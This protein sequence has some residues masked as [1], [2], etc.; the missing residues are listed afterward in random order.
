MTD[1]IDIDIE[2][3]N[4]VVASMALHSVAAISKGQELVRASAQRVV[5]TSQQLV[6]VD[7]AA[8]R[9]SIHA[10]PTDGGLGAEI[11][12]TTSY[13]PYLE[14]GTVKMAPRAFMGPALDRETPGFIE[15]AA[16]IPDLLG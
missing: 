9:N 12:P 1:R 15:G 14:F 10:T 6:P 11:G 7:T 13:A 2:G 3:L 16:Q 4:T 5:A 8:T